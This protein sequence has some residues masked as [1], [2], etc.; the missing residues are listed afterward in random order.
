M[1]ARHTGAD[2]AMRAVAL[3]G[4]RS[5]KSMREIAID[6]YGAPVPDSTGKK[7]PSIVFS[8]Q[9]TAPPEILGM[10][11]PKPFRPRAEN[12]AGTRSTQ[13]SRKASR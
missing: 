9:M 8:E 11:Q 6:F 3:T 7:R 2:A 13:R 5:G 12:R 4:I 10:A 1:T